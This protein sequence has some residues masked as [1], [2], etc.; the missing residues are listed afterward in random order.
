VN[1]RSDSS[2]TA[3]FGIKPQKSV[4]EDTNIVYISNPISS[5]FISTVTSA[6][7]FF[8]HEMPKTPKK[9]INEPHH[10]IDLHKERIFSPERHE[11]PKVGFRITCRKT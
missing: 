9:P 1:K 7:D 4:S 6:I 3:T 5:D 11:N 8:S 2:N 10:S